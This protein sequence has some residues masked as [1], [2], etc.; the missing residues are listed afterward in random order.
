M[1][2]AI[3]P[4]LKDVTLSY[5]Y[6]NNSPVNGEVFHFRTNSTTC[7]LKSIIG[8]ILLSPFS[9][10]GGGGGSDE[11][12]SAHHTCNMVGIADCALEGGII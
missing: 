8:Q 5:R 12:V 4:W 7:K 9:G 6:K 10:D 1:H 2:H 3:I 11:A